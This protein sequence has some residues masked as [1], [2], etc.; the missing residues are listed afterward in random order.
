MEKRVRSSVIAG[1][2]YPGG[3]KDLI[4]HIENYFKQVKD[5]DLKGDVIGIIISKCDSEESFT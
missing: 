3:Q 5:V 4:L 2:W 1:T